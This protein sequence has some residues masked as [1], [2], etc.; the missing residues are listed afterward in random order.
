MHTH[1]LGRDRVCVCGEGVGDNCG[2]N[3]KGKHSCMFQLGCQSWLPDHLSV[4]VG[5]PGL[6]T[7]TSVSWTCKDQDPPLLPRV[8]PPPPSGAPSS[9]PHPCSC[10]WLPG[11]GDRRAEKGWTSVFQVPEKCP[12]LPS[13]TG[14]PSPLFLSRPQFPHLEIEGRLGTGASHLAAQEAEIRRMEV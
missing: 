13:S 6:P 2:C 7:S 12:C 11:N 4:E 9:C 14:S 8:S 3:R 5:V 10:F 1:Q